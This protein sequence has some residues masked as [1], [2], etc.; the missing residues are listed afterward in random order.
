M[1]KSDYVIVGSGINSLVCAAILAKGGH[2]VCVLERNNRIGGCIRSEELTTPGF[3][4]DVMAA[5]FVLFITSPAYAALAEDL[6]QRGLEFCDSEFPTGVLL[7]D[8]RHVIYGR[9]TDRNSTAFD[10]LGG[11]DGQQHA[12]DM[13]EI[14]ANADLLFSL[15]GGNLWSWTMAKILFR[16]GRRRGTRELLALL[17]EALGTA[18]GWLETTY[19]SEEIRALWAP[20]VLHAG[21]GPESAFSAQIAKIIAFA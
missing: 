11:K 4:H 18:R 1:N 20:W 2:S 6:H 12:D 10:A 9:S 19:S 17:G 8:G 5:T 13:A 7:A 21:L 15:L 3:T 16:E 14:G